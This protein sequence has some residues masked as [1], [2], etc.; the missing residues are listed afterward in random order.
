MV[1]FGMSLSFA[2][3]SLGDHMSLPSH[4]TRVQ[5]ANVAPQSVSNLLCCE[6]PIIVCIKLSEEMRQRI[7]IYL[8]RNTP[9][10]LPNLHA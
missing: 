4:L 2:C 8:R 9:L 7:I 6:M 1:L 3:L 10:A 5:G